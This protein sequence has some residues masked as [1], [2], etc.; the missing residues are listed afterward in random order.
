LSNFAD[1]IGSQWLSNGSGG[2][3]CD[4]KNYSAKA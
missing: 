3:Y 2:N 1:T 4:L